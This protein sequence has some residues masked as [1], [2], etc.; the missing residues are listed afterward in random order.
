MND[1]VNNPKHYNANGIYECFDFTVH[2]DFVHGN[3]FKYVFRHE[4]KNGLEDLL[5]AQ[6]YINHRHEM[7][8]DAIKRHILIKM[9]E[10]MN[11][12]LDVSLHNSLETFIDGATGYANTTH[13][14]YEIKYLIDRWENSH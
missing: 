14:Q 13:L 7:K 10:K 8:M 9:L 1:N 5:K 12:V 4:Q 2:M 3:I 11:Q 6:W